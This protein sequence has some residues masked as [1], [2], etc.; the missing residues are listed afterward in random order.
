M[1]SYTRASPG[2]GEEHFERSRFMN[3]VSRNREY[4]G[5]TLSELLSHRGCHTSMRE[6]SRGE[7]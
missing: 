2:G 7:I 3:A 4:T 6:G 1:L 5:N